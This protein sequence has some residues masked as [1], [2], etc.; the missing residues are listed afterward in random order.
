MKKIIIAAMIG[1]SSSMIAQVPTSGLVSSWEFNGGLGTDGTGSNHG[2]IHGATAIQ[3]RCGNNASAL[4]FNGTSDY[5]IMTNAGPLGNSAR[6]LSFWMRTNNTAF[7]DQFPSTSNP[8]CVRAMFNYGVWTTAS[9]GSRWEIHHNYNCLGLGV[10]ISA[11]YFTKAANCVTNNDWHHIV[12]TQAQGA[13]LTAAK[14]YYDGILLTTPNCMLVGPSTSPN[15]TSNDVITIGCIKIPTSQVPSGFSRFFLGDL[16]DFFLYNRELTPT[17]V[18]NLYNE[19]CTMNP[20][21]CTNVAPPVDPDPP[22]GSGC[23][24]GNYCGKSQNKLFGNY[25]I[26]LDKFNFNFSNDLDNL[27]KVNIGYNCNLFDIGKLNAVTSKL[28]NLG[29]AGGSGTPESISIYGKNTFNRTS[30][31]GVGVM[32]EAMN[33]EIGNS[34][35][36]WGNATGQGDNTGGKFFAGRMPLTF[37]SYN[38]G[39]SATVLNPAPYNYIASYP[40][41]ANIGVYGA[42]AFQQPIDQSSAPTNEYAAWF[43]G[44]VNFVGNVFG[45][46]FSWTSDKRFKTNIKELATVTEKLLQLK[47]YTYMFKTEEFK[48]R[49]FPKSEQIGFIAQELKEL[50]PQLVVDDKQGYL[51]VNYVGFIPVLLEGFKEQQ[52]QM[53][54]Q[55]QQINELKAL[56]NSLAG[57]NTGNKSG[58]I[59]STVVNLSDKNAVVLNQNVPNPFAESTVI[60]YLIPGNF[61]KAQMIFTTT[62]GKL[63]KVVDITENAGALNIFANDLSNGVYS[64]A[65]VVDGKTLDTKKMIKQ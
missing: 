45:S 12:I 62:D 65:L 1:L 61:I 5:V 59:N 54:K 36:V 17:E 48:N 22:V 14:V 21:P 37:G 19:K 43:D 7:G 64:Y 2:T 30:M 44:D 46:Q 24:L 4:H 11:T 63:V 42:S 13:A 33:N 9:A 18:V 50:F 3:D 41:G 32:G 53:E 26:P 27:T 29:S 34:V 40:G 8:G 31:T 28:T 16:D 15:N 20:V 57:N 38:V 25:E 23:C 10:D 58:A 51:A 35:G 49:N 47:S 56:V 55:Q 60:N 39:M 6:S 52:T